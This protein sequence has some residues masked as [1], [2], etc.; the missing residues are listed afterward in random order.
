MIKDEGLLASARKG[1]K[2]IGQADL[3]KYLSGG[4]LTQRQSIKAKCYDCNG[5]GETVECSFS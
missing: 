4:K 3:I 2:K 1:K 5:M